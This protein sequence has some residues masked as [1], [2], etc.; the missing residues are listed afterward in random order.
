[1]DFKVFNTID[2]GKDE[3]G[4]IRAL[5]AEYWNQDPLT[6]KAK[7]TSSNFSLEIHFFPV[8]RIT[9]KS[10]VSSNF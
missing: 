9:L 10:V 5:E 8:S 4:D 2:Q 7:A 1:M 6:T 3:S